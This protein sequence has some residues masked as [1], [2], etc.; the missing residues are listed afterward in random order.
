MS[1][2]ITPQDVAA[3]ALQLGHE[4]VDHIFD[5]HAEAEPTVFTE[6]VRKMWS[7]GFLS[8]FSSGFTTGAMR[9][10]A[11]IDQMPRTRIPQQGAN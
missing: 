4:Y 7:L 5:L 11:V 9:A 6:D 8:G 2:G 1:E 10:K 3:A